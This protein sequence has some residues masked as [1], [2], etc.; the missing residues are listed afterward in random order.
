VQPGCSHRA[1]VLIQ[2]MPVVRSEVVTLGDRH[3]SRNAAATSKRA[4]HRQGELTLA[5]EHALQE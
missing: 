3:Q 1:R 2:G 4:R 5:L